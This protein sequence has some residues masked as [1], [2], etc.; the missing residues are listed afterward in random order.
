MVAL[1]RQRAIA[2]NI[3]FYEELFRS[4]NIRFCKTNTVFYTTQKA[5][6]LISNI[7]TR[8]RGWQPDDHFQQIDKAAKNFAWDS[9]SIKDSFSVL[10]LSRLGFEKLFHA[11]WFYLEGSAFK[12]SENSASLRWDLIRGRRELAAWRLAWN[13]NES[14][15]NVADLIFGDRLLENPRMRF[16]A[17]YEGESLVAGCILNRTEPVFGI[18]NFFAT[19]DSAAT[20]SGIIEFIRTSVTSNDLVGY[21][22]A[23]M[24]DRSL[25]GLGFEQVGDLAVWIKKTP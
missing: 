17:G 24:I 9:W 10:N 19:D 8:S 16:I 6:P 3:G 18:S 23:P 13:K 5:L 12:R 14:G 21:E 1:K 7:V 4:N 20:W 15:G 2:N 11:T 25:A 22:Q